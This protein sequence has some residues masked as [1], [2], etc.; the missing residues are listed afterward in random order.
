MILLAADAIQAL[1]VAAQAGLILGEAGDFG[2]GLAD[3]GVVGGNL[4]LLLGDLVELTAR[5]FVQGFVLDV[6]GEDVG[7]QVGA[8][9]MINT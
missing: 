9:L 1:D 3:G 8:A 6:D 5:V 7:R 2:F 4:T